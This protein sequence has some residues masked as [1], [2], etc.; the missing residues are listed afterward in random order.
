M[1]WLKVIY[2]WHVENLIDIRGTELVYDV[3]TT[4]HVAQAFFWRRFWSGRLARLRSCMAAS[5]CGR[6]RNGNT[7][8]RRPSWAGRP[9]YS[10]PRSWRPGTAIK[11]PCPSVRT[12]TE[13]VL[14]A[15]RIYEFLHRKFYSPILCSLKEWN[16]F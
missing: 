4:G 5:W 1:K 8:W 9:P 2:L 12:A 14:L 6:S 16:Y 15:Y 3:L 11:W 7:R 10:A 13:E